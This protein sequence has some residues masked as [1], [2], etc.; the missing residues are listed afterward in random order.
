MLLRGMRGKL[1]D[2]GRGVAPYFVIFKGNSY[3]LI[4][5]KSETV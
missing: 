4:I 5:E 3:R 2:F 1:L